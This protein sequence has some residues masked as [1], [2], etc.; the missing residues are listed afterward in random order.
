M[1]LILQD[2]LGVSRNKNN[3]FVFL[4]EKKNVNTEKVSKLFKIRV[5]LIF[6]TIKFTLEM[7]K[8]K[9]FRITK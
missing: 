1:Y 7:L 3:K 9:F 2:L 6:R 4:E 5:S 8:L